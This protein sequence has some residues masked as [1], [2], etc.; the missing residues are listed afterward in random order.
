M[1]R[2]EALGSLESRMKERVTGAVAAQEMHEP[3]AP[4]VTGGSV[5]AAAVSE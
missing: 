3:E 4:G 2:R 5:T 1:P